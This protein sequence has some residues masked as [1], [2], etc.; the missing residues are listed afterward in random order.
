M[1]I[2]ICGFKSGC[3]HFL[4]KR[5]KKIK[6]WA[7]HVRT[8]LSENKTHGDT[9]HVALSLEFL[10]KKENALSKDIHLLNALSPEF[11]MNSK[12]TLFILTEHF[13]TKGFPI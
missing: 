5:I 7:G 9:E 8:R 13:L 10:S 12:K 11:T 6:M 2:L 1:N 4:N 3:R